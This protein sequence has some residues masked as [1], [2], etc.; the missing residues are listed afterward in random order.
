MRK[1]RSGLVVVTAGMAILG[2]PAL[3]WA[4]GSGSGRAS[5]QEVG[6]GMLLFAS[7]IMFAIISGLVVAVVLFFRRYIG[8]IP[9]KTAPSSES[10]ANTSLDA[11]K[12]R[13]ARGDIDKDKFEEK[14]RSLD[15]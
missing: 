14:R 11:L 7:L 6:L 3:A 1:N 5:I 9:V 10:A 2:F 15:D 12:E 13:I 8:A 4:A